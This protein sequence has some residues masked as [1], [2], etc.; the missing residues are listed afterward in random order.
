MLLN[1]N[2]LLLGFELR[3]IQRVW[4]GLLAVQLLSLIV[5]WI[6][7]AAFEGGAVASLTI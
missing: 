3:N 1:L 5:R 6:I 2:S 4:L 7:L